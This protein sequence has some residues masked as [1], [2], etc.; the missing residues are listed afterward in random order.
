MSLPGVDASGQQRRCRLSLARHEHRRLLG[1]FIRAHR[2][3][4]APPAKAVGR[5]RTPGWRREELADAA[6]LGVTWI[7]W[8]EQGRPVNASVPALCRLAEALQLTPVER[9]SL[10]DLAGKRDP[11]AGHAPTTD[12]P[13]ELLSLPAQVCAPAYLLDQSYAAIAW[14]ERAAELLVGWLD[15][16]AAQP[17]LLEF[18]FLSEHARDLLVDW[19]D[20]ARRLVAE[21]RADFNRHA[22]DVRLQAL[23]ESL[24]DRSPDF[25]RIWRSQDVLNRDG[26][27]RT[28]SH[29]VR[30]ESQFF[31][32]TFQL[33]SHAGVKLVCL[34]PL[35]RDA[36]Q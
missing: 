19:P 25:E 4:L 15:K 6:G 10:F 21:F 26:G 29:P 3:R 18:V 34:L 5:L 22:G 36:G 24:A 35:C 12:L 23:A 9:M 33:A 17:N 13:A 8:L 20:R 31:Q 30:G 7:T 2:E 27:V 28:F 16:G 32:T 14:N 1:A 11:L